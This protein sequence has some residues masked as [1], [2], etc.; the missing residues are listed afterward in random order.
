MKK[1][2]FLL[3]YFTICIS[4]VLAVNTPV[5]VLNET[6]ISDVYDAVK[7]GLIHCDDLEV[8]KEIRGII[9]SIKLKNPEDN[10]YRFTPELIEKL[11]CV[12]YFLAKIKNPVII[13]VHTDKVPEGIRMKNWEYSSILAAKIGD[14]FMKREP[15]LP[16]ERIFSVGYGEFMPDINTSNNGGNNN[17][18]IDIIIQS[19]I[20]G[21]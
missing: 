9:I 15:K 5:Y 12:E 19:S 3:L 7:Q 11:S 18:R 1:T 10:Y 14:M 16:A 21:E 8:R 20:S 2:V 13:E 6:E 4:A 17:N